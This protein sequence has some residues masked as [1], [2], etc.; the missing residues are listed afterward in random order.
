[1]AFIKIHFDYCQ[2]YND[3]AKKRNDCIR[4]TPYVINVQN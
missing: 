3:L 4:A 1:M 2:F